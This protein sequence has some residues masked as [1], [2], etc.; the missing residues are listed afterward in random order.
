M[1]LDLVQLKIT[2]K[3]IRSITGLE[4]YKESWFDSSSFL[5]GAVDNYASGIVVISAII[6]FSLSSLAICWWL[7]VRSDSD[8]LSW[9]EKFLNGGKI[10][11]A[12]ILAALPTWCVGW[13]TYGI[14]SSKYQKVSRTVIKLVEEIEK[15]HNLI[16]A[17]HIQDQLEAVGNTVRL[18]DRNQVIKALEI[19]RSDII[20]ALKTEKIIRENEYFVKQNSELFASGLIALQA[21]QIEESASEY[22]LFLDNALQI[23][24]EIQD[25]MRNL[26][27]DMTDSNKKSKNISFKLD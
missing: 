4:N 7:G 9:L 20:R 2:N 3:E 22:G 13:A 1:K 24:I 16:K 21:L 12:I 6:C 17:I 23:G 5:S 27:T 19:T 11:L 15:F 8:Y 25:E 26:Q 10:L 14:A 18:K